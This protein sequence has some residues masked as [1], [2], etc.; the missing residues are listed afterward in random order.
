[1]RLVCDCGLHYDGV[2][3]HDGLDKRRVE[4]T[5]QAGIIFYED[6]K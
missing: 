1:M 5:S 4:R 2:R 3:I 6:P